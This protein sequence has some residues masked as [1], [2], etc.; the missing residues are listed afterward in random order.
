MWCWLSFAALAAEPTMEELLLATD[1]AGR[2]E[3]SI[4]VMSMQVKTDR[5]ERTMKMKTWAKGAE[6]TLV[7]ILEPEKDA[8]VT[9]LKVDDNLWNYLP[10]VD[11]TM[12]VPAGMMSG[13][14]MGS[15]FS[16]DDLVRDSRLSDDFTCQI[17]GRPADS[18][19]NYVVTCTPK[20]DAAVVWGKVAATVTPDKAPVEVQFWDEAGVLVRTM[21]YGNVKDVKGRK[22][23]MEMTLTPHDKPGEF[24]KIVFESLDLDAQVDDAMFSLQS[25]QQR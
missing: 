22:M 5:Y 8:G 11:R 24:T 23:P 13:S 19:G 12:K 4:A 9:T 20:P 2:G 10:K 18:G 17:T 6:K 3:Q 14:W 7:R 1:D 15:H 25:L 21:S 16:N